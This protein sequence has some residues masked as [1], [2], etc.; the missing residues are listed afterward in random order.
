MGSFAD[1]RRSEGLVL[2]RREYLLAGLALTFLKIAVDWS[3]A[4]GLFHRQWALR[5]YVFPGEL[6]GLARMAPEDRTFYTTLA[7][8]AVPF[9]AVGVTLT[10]R[11]LRD[12]GLT[13]WLVLL[14]F[15]PLPF[16]VVFF[17]ILS[18]IRSRRNDPLAAFRDLPGEPIPGKKKAL[19]TSLQFD[20]TP[21]AS[22]FPENDWACALVSVLITMPITAVLCLLSIDVL[23]TYGW[24]LFLGVPFG[25]TMAAVVLFGLRK[26]RDVGQCLGVGCLW[27]F[28]SLAMLVIF[29]I[30]GAICVIMLAP[31]ALPIVLLAAWAGYLVHRSSW[32]PHVPLALWLILVFNP[33]MIA[34]EGLAPRTPPLYQVT[35][36]LEVDAPPEIVWQH[37][38]EFPK[39]PPPDD[40][41]FR[42]GIAYPIRATI[43]GRGAGAVRKCE[44]STGAFVEPIEVWEEPRLLRFSVTSNPPPMKEWSPFSD[45]HPRHLDDYLVSRRGEFRLVPLPEGRTRLV[46]STWYRHTMWPAAYWKL[47]SDAII[48]RIHLQVLRHVKRQA[49]GLGSKPAETLPRERIT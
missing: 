40:W 27:F 48:H 46:G 8:I 39:L 45:I 24:G 44:F 20:V 1:P 25:M 26:P 12:A 14:F 29:G 38:I 18:A 6:F 17:L 11:R 16:N 4:V 49:E 9:V 13:P 33:T 22:M 35:T 31:L 41:V 42:T 23:N 37:V 10:L 30:D 32:S 19:P 15:L 34:A 3:V 2:G 47:W 7:T 5:R 36:A 43:D 21:L 28:A